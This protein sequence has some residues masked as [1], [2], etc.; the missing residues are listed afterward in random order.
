MQVSE[1]HKNSYLKC[2]NHSKLYTLKSPKRGKTLKKL[3][4][5][6]AFGCNYLRTLTTAPATAVTTLRL[7]AL[8]TCQLVKGLFIGDKYRI[9]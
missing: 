8:L 2:D 1:T 4:V 9:D 3:L 5:N 6:P 7:N